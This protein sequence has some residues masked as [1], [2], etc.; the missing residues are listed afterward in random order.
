MQ[1]EPDSEHQGMR[2]TG[3]LLWTWNNPQRRD[4]STFKFSDQNIK[5]KVKRKAEIS[6]W[7]FRVTGP[8]SSRLY[9]RT[10]TWSSASPWRWSSRHGSVFQ[11]LKTWNSS[12]ISGRFKC[13]SGWVFL[14]ARQLFVICYCLVSSLL[15]LKCQCDK[16][17]HF[18]WLFKKNARGFYGS[19][20]HR[21]RI[22]A[23]KK[24]SEAEQLSGL[25]QYIF[26][27]ALH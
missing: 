11:F 2:L 1:A 13:R 25:F 9:A 22:R 20:W 14:K 6:S 16:G 8:T 21:S 27:F 10:L 24:L 4:Q 19:F 17:H 12:L 26:L 5:P 7:S 23:H 18:K 3:R 15:S